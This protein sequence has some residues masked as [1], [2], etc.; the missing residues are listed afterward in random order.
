L[1]EPIQ[2]DPDGYIAVP[3][4]PGLG[5]EVDERAIARYSKN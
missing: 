2:I 4:K 5:V 1:K 3:H